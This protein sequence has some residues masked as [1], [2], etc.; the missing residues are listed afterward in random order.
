MES[1]LEFCKFYLHNTLNTIKN[2]LKMLSLD[3][4][5]KS[6]TIV[7]KMVILVKFKCLLSDFQFSIITL[8][9]EIQ[10]L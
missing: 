6:L 10:K 1:F 8:N 3:F 9:V 2:E 7:S 5:V 4:N